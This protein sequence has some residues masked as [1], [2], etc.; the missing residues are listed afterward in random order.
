MNFFQ[1]FIAMTKDERG[2]VMPEYALLLGLIAAIAVG[3]ISSMGTSV[4][5]IFSAVNT[6]LTTAAGTA[7]R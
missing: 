2:A 3:T 6:K 1:S 7:G 4:N 5:P